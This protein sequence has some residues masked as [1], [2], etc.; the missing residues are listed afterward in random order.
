MGELYKKISTAITKH[1]DLD[2]SSEELRASIIEFIAIEFHRSVIA[3]DTFL[4][5]YKTKQQRENDEVDSI[6]FRMGK[7]T[8]E[9]NEY[10]ANF[11]QKAKS[12]EIFRNYAQNILGTSNLAISALYGGF[13]P[14]I[15]YI[16][17]G[18][19]YQFLLPP[20]HFVANELFAYFILSPNIALALVSEVDNNLPLLAVEK[21]RVEII[22]LRVLECASSL[23]FGFREIVGGK[24]RL[25]QLQRQ[26]ER[27]KSVAIISENE[28]IIDDYQRFCFITIDDVFEFVIIL[29]MFFA[30]KKGIHKV[31]MKIENFDKK[32]FYES[33]N[34]IAEMFKKYSFE[35]LL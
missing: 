33:R 25:E 22:N 32:F 13:S 20:L 21:E 1:T 5:K 2:V 27:V 7:M 12:K 6:L 34:E 31:R 29:S 23:D 15:L 10:S 4:E 30:H 11:R 9:R 8:M 26:I 17:S 18:S 35:L 19:E 24:A 3:N 14:Q 16:P 28:T